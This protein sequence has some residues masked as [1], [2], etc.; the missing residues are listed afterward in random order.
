[1]LRSSRGHEDPS[2]VGSPGSPRVTLTPPGLDSLHSELCLAI[3]PWGGLI[4]CVWSSIP[5][6]DRRVLV[7]S[8]RVHPTS[9]A[10]GTPNPALSAIDR[11]SDAE[12]RSEESKPNQRE[13]STWQKFGNGH[14]AVLSLGYA[15]RAALRVARAVLAMRARYEAVIG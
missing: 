12:R 2:T 7:Q 10:G 13:M 5:P 11:L 8:S 9:R 1:M 15:L 14:Q 3:S 4:S 6:V